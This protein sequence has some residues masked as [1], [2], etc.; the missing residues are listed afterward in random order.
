MPLF[1][2]TTD[3]ARCTVHDFTRLGWSVIPLRGDQNP[4]LSKV[5]ALPSWK[6]Y[7]QRPPS[8]AEVERW[9]RAQPDRPFGVVL[10]PVS[11]I[12]VVDIDSQ[13]IAEQ[14]R[15][16]M[17]D[18][19][20]T[21]M[22]ESGNRRLPHYY[23]RI[24]K[25]VKVPSRNAPGIELRSEGQYVVAPGSVIG[26][27]VW[28]LS[29]DQTPRI[30]SESDLERILAFLEDTRAKAAANALE[31]VS[32]ASSGASDNADALETAHYD[33]TAKSIARRYR[34]LAEQ[35]GRNNALFSVARFARDC[36]WSELATR[37]ALVELHRDTR[38]GP[39]HRSET[40]TQRIAEATRTIAS[41]YSRPA[42]RIGR[43][44]RWTPQL[45][46]SVR[47]ALMKQGMTQAARLLDALCILG[48]APG[49]CLTA[50]SV[51]ARV[52]EFGIGRNSVYRTLR[53]T[54]ENGK[55]LF[56][57]ENPS[58]PLDPHTPYAIAANTTDSEINQCLF[59]WV[60]KPVKSAGRP[61]RVYK[62][63]TISGLCRLLGVRNRGGDHLEADAL[64]SPTT[65]R[66]ALHRAFIA[67]TP[68][69]HSR[70]W[71]SERLGVC[72][73]TV[74]RYERNSDIV[75]TPM[76]WETPLTWRNI[77]A[78]LSDEPV[79]GC[80]LEDHRGKRYP[81]LRPLARMLLASHRRLTFK[82]QLI[83]DYRI[84]APP[85]VVAESQAGKIVPRPAERP[86]PELAASRRA[87]RALGAPWSRTLRAMREKRAR[88]KVNARD[89]MAEKVVRTAARRPRPVYEFW[90]RT[91]ETTGG[92]EAYSKADLR[93]RCAARVCAILRD[94]DGDH[95]LTKQAATKLVD[96]YGIKGVER[97]LAT[98][99]SR[100]NIRNPAGF[101]IVWLRSEASPVD[102]Q[103]APIRPDGRVREQKTQTG[104]EW[105]AAMKASPY[106]AFLANAEDLID[107]E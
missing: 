3:F 24:A 30:L 94:M 36:G 47:E 20:A 52:S 91:L 43:S 39:A 74:R 58:F 46:N 17:P 15:T 38:S 32:A 55:A 89:K 34:Q 81:P 76:F 31:T 10:G 49:S 60:A 12:V 78:A 86:G 69:Q 107:H 63:P 106:A 33:I 2:N 77:E 88:A 16:A 62:M 37:K 26:G 5:P 64:Q 25:G 71:L 102:N 103:A 40:P 50:S 98:L 22:I 23:Y 72:R 28:R 18:L 67:R 59:D 82:R 83:N 104:S 75:V 95:A 87:K 35:I 53:A 45:P 9:I 70:A 92:G 101:L 99:Q 96:R 42:R 57:V 73:D 56:D 97:G 11:G 4:A 85:P 68:G 27:R 79:D 65:Y 84:A 21:L 105:S 44:G 41:V 13:E 14:F 6:T 51:Y 54:L 80:F 90:A 66:A 61:E 93:E 1:A 100:S 7:Q 8:S 19:A 29:C 48:V